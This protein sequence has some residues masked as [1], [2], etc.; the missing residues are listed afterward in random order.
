[1]APFLNPVFT[2]I[3][4]GN[5]SDNNTTN[6]TAGNDNIVLDD[7]NDTSNGLDGDDLNPHFSQTELRT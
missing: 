5:L 3:F 4:D 1:M 2:D 6:G 7:G